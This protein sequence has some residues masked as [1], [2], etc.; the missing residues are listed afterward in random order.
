MNINPMKS[1]WIQNDK[2]KNEI[3][4]DKMTS[5]ISKKIETQFR[6]LIIN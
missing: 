6:L 3:E 5:S 4:N 2:P 1:W